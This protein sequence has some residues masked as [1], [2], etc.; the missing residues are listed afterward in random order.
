MEIARAAVGHAA[1]EPAE[2]GQLGGV[3]SEAL[4]ALR[5]GWGDAY[6]IEGDSDSDAVRARRKDG[7][8]GWLSADD[9]ESLRKLIFDDY[10]LMPV[11]REDAP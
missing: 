9:T 2:D 4:E 6:M 7:R 5:F 8:G 1:E 3:D 11:S 10:T